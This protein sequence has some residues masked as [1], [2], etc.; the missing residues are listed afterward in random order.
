MESL[1]SIRSRF[2]NLRMLAILGAVALALTTREASATPYYSATW[3]DC[4]ANQGCLGWQTFHLGGGPVRANGIQDSSNAASAFVWGVSYWNSAGTVASYQVNV[5]PQNFPLARLAAYRYGYHGS[6][7]AQVWKYDMLAN[8]AFSVCLLNCLASG[9]ANALPG[10][11]LSEVIYYDNQIALGGLG[12]SDLITVSRHELGHVGGLTDH[13][14]G[15]YNDLMVGT[16]SPSQGTT[17]SCSEK[18]GVS[19]VHDRATVC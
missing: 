15:G 19:Y 10:Y 12:L 7:I 18:N 1:A 6:Y 16:Y 5:P 2:R 14:E 8:G 13:N 4:A 11:D 9:H 3:N 17:L